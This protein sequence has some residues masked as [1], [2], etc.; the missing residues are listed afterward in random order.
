MKRSI[1]STFAV[2]VLAVTAIPALASTR[3]VTLKDDSFSPSRLTVTK[4]TTVK[5]KWTG[6]EPHNV[7]GSG[8]S[9]FRSS[10]KDSG[11]YS[12]RLTHIHSGM[13]LRLTVR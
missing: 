3:T 2:A 12:K 13:R 4:G 8:P 5:F 9:S 7:I 6:G 1:V 11:T 10:T